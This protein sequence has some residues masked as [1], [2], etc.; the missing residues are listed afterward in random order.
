M[1]VFIVKSLEVLCYLGF[2][3]FII[4]GALFFYL[5]IGAAT[6]PVPNPV[7]TRV[8]AVVAGAIAGFIAA[9]IVFGTLF[10]LLDIADN[11]RRTREL[12]ERRP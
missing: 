7:A 9:V 8:V 12:L 2:F 10:L 1:K 6:V 5:S 4:G 3:G 11:T